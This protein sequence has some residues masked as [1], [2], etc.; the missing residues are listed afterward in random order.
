LRRT[1]DGQVAIVTGGAAGIGLACVQRLADEGAMVVLVDR[2]AAAAE[3]AAQRSGEAVVSFAA[4]AT[5]GEA[6][7]EVFDTVVRRSDRLDVLVNG[8]GGF[9]EA[10]L[11]EDLS[12][13]HWETVLALNLTSAYLCCRQ[14]VPPM[15][16]AGYGRIVN[17]ASMAGRTAARGISHAYAAA[18]AGLIGLTR[19]LA[20]ELA[21]QGITVNAVAPGV[22]LSPRV[23]RL[24]AHRMDE[25]LAETPI[26]R[27]AEAAE[28][29]D[30]VWYLASPGSSYVTG[31]TI[32]V[33]GGRFIG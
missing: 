33:T 7:A 16:A 22:V 1:L 12:P 6:V 24:H 13:S 3:A 4:D 11:I 29:A 27:P 18:K 15:K 19:G 31:A 28:V 14:A 30:V 32:D 8:A 9:T 17:I 25:I 21:T 20:L 26:G 5:D 10:P 2:D 23:Q